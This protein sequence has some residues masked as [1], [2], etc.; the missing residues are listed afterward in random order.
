M[1]KEE[2][3]SLCERILLDLDNIFRKDIKM[4]KIL[5]RSKE[6]LADLEFSELVLERK[7]KCASVFN[8][9]EWIF[10]YFRQSFLTDPE[11]AE[12]LVANELRV[13]LKASDKYP[14]NYYAWSHRSWLLL[15]FLKNFS[16]EFL[17]DKIIEDLRTTTEWLQKHISDYSCFQYRQHL[18]NFVH[19]LHNRNNRIN[20]RNNVNHKTINNHNDGQCDFESSNTAK[21]SSEN[22]FLKSLD[23]FAS[24]TNHKNSSNHF[25]MSSFCWTACGNSIQIKNV[26]IYIAVIY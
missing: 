1:D 18:F 16:F 3:G 22:D 23:R 10:N 15:I 6:Y 7:P 9:R 2:I 26:Y 5:I 24:N 25:L 19:S 21:F 20:H 13:T 17:I 8:Y 4:R 11:L 12:N 14:R